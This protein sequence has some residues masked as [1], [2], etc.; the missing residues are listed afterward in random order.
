[1][2]NQTN[3]PTLNF[4]IE[5]STAMVCEE[6]GNDTFITVFYIRKASKFLVGSPQ[7]IIQPFPS[8]ACSKCHHVNKDLSFNLEN[9]EEDGI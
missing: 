2:Q 4:P 8:F 5:Q 7:D 3:Q 9:N 6:C 1:M